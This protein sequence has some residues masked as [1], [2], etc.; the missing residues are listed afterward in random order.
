MMMMIVVVVV[1][2]I[3]TMV[4]VRNTVVPSILINILFTIACV[5]IHLADIS[6]YVIYLLSGDNYT[7]NFYSYATILNARSIDR[8]DIIINDDVHQILHVLLR[9]DQNPHDVRSPH[10]ARN[11]RIHRGDDDPCARILS[12]P[13]HMK[14][15]H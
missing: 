5:F 10:D 13:C 6:H 12:S 7:T 14:V 1:V 8:I 9:D 11:L 3:I 15:R 2:R 4:V